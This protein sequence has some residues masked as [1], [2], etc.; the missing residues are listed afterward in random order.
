MRTILGYALHPDVKWLLPEGPV[1]YT[2][3]RNEDQRNMLYSEIRKLYLFVEGGNN[4]LTQFKREMLFIDM[5]QSI[6]QEDAE[7]L[8]SVKDKKLPYQGLTYNIIKKA[9]PDLLP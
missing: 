6:D 2:P 8:I 1:P 7:M 3:N 4:N 5:L 9:F